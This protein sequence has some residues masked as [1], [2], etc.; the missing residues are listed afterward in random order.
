M[1]TAFQPVYKRDW[2]LCHNSEFHVLPAGIY[3]LLALLAEELVDVHCIAVYCSVLQCIAVY[4]SV[5][6][7]IAVYRSVLQC[8]AVYCSVL[9]CIAVYCSVLQCIAVYCSV[10]QCI[11]VYRSVL[12]CIAV[13]C[14]V[15]QC[16]AVYCSV[17]QCIVVYVLPM[18]TTKNTEWQCTVVGVEIR[19]NDAGPA[20]SVRTERCMRNARVDRMRTHGCMASALGP[21][22]LRPDF[23]VHG[24]T[25]FP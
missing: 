10:L 13:Y 2:K 7:C 12:Q 4:C 1:L 15:L 11:A 16:I 8:I 18:N 19:S 20:P 3:M 6:Q 14:S 5:L 23:H 21:L 17:L 9:Q 24:R 25:C 22:D